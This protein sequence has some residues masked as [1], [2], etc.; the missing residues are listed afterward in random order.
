VKLLRRKIDVRSL[1]EAKNRPKPSNRMFLSVREE[2][3]NIDAESPEKTSSWE[4][5]LDSYIAIASDIRK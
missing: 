2:L 3:F 4:N 1:N 5:Q